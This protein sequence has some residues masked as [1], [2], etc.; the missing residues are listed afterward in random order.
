MRSTP[1]DCSAS[2]ASAIASTRRP[3]YRITCVPAKMPALA[4]ILPIPFEEGAIDKVR[5]TALQG[6]A[7]LLPHALCGY[8]Q[9]LAHRDGEFWAG[10]RTY[11]DYLRDQAQVDGHARLP[12][13][14]AHIYLG[15]EMGLHFAQ[16]IGAL[17]SAKVEALCQE[18]WQVFMALARAHARTL[19]DE[20]PTKV[21]L[22]T[23]EEAL[24]LGEAHLAD[25]TTGVVVIGKPGTP[26]LGWVDEDHV[27]L[28]PG[29]A[30]G[31]VAQRV[32]PH[33]RFPLNRKALTTMMAADGVIQRAEKDRHT[34]QVRISGHKNKVRVWCLGSADLGLPG[35]S[36]GATWPE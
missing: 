14:V 20:R 8:V 26:L 27:Y 9:D 28:V 10:L 18:G 3:A 23:L 32:R 11:V 35:I 1:I 5:L 6:Q 22:E 25:R 33:G 34:F 30:Y 2:L 17:D 29:A 24:S 7:K 19:T 16:R 12:E 36:A 21:F 4:R 13:T 31:F 15:F